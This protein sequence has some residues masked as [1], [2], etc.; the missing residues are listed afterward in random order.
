[1]AIE[2]VAQSS[3]LQSSV[4]VQKSSTDQEKLSANVALEEG[5]TGGSLESSPQG[6]NGGLVD[7]YA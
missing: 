3:Q 1:M 7:I 4:Q 5:K 2:G 6:G